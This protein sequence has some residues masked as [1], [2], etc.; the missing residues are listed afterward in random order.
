M[1]LYSIIG[2]VLAV[3][4]LVTGIIIKLVLRKHREDLDGCRGLV[5]KDEAQTN[6]PGWETIE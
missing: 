1:S 2:I 6:D 3:I 5:H 4:T